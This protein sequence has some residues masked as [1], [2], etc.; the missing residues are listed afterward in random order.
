MA[1][2][3]KILAFPWENLGF[4]R[5]RG[6]WRALG[7]HL[8]G[9]SRAFGVHLESKLRL[10]ALGQPQ[11][12]PSEPGRAVQEAHEVQ[13]QLDEVVSSDVNIE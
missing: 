13:L 3:T 1:R 10:G 5:F 9:S 12:A 2:S 7:E 6:L 4:S 11:T 8:G